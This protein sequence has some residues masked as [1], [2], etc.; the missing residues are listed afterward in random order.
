MTV[1]E[2]CGIL[3][4]R[5]DML[6]S[7]YPD[8]GAVMSLSLDNW[9]GEQLTCSGGDANCSNGVANGA[10]LKSRTYTEQSYLGV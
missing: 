5:V 4:S 2:R 3:T 7:H 10:D 1:E 9:S 8:M 6:R